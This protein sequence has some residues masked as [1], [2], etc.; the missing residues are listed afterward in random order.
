MT[1]KDKVEISKNGKKTDNKVNT[2]NKNDNE[3]EQILEEN[4]SDDNSIDKDVAD[5]ENKG[6]SLKKELEDVNNKLVR[7]QA[8]FL[9]YKARTEKEKFTTYNNAVADLITELLPI[10]D[11]FERAVEAVDEKNTNQDVINFKNGIDMIYTQLINTLKKRGLTEIEALNSKF[12]PNLHSGIAIETVKDKDEDTIIEV[13]Q[14][15]YT[16]NDKVIRPSVVK[17]AKN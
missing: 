5:E 4:K 3:T 9:N 17:I 11:N 15:G 7:L 8:D 6:D 2:E 13:F 16:V 10:I 1:K 14:K 12:D